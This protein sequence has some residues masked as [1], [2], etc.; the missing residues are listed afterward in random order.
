[1]RQPIPIAAARRIARAYGYDQIVIYGR[2]VGEAPDGGEHLTTYG[3]TPE[4]CSVAAR[5]SEVLQK[6]M[7][8]KL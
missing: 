6:F 8:W 7:G 1:M 3:T 5:M 2:R 4:H